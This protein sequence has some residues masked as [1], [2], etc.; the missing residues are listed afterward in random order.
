QK[1]GYINTHGTS[2]PIG[3]LKEA[4]AI[5]EVFG[6]EVPPFASTKS[7]TGHSLGAVGAQE[8]VFSL[9]QMK[10]R[11][12]AASANIQTLGDEFKDLPVIRE[13]RERIDVDAILTNSFGFG[14]TNASLVAARY[15]K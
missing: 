7:L 1:I 5:Q 4:A 9:L 14:G 8:L 10:E 2:T 12:L 13:L 6:S 3:D 11:F 15:E